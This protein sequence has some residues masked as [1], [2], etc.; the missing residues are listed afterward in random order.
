MY[1]L[2]QNRPGIGD[3]GRPD[4]ACQRHAGFPT[5]PLHGQPEWCILDVMSEMDYRQ[6]EQD[7]EILAEI[8]RHLFP[9]DL[10][11][12]VRL[13]KDLADRGLAAWSR[14]EEGETLP[15]DET[16]EQRQARHRAGELGLIGLSVETNGVPDGDDVVVQLEAW[17]IGAA[18]AVA[19]EVGL[20]T[21]LKPPPA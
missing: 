17:G 8:G 20:L 15:P 5:I 13:S 3:P 18:L 21:D 7:A 4:L 11:I 10:K 14:D 12:T 9:Q 6:W 19:D 2:G 16:P 1:V